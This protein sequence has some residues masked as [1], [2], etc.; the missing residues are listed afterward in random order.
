MAVQDYASTI[1]VVMWIQVAIA[2]AFIGMRMYTRYF[3]IRSVGL[4]D[5]IMLFNLVRPMHCP[6]NLLLLK[7]PALFLRLCRL[8]NDRSHL[9]HRQEVRCRGTLPLLQSHHVG[10]HRSRDMHSRDCRLQKLSRCLP[11]TYCHSQM[12]RLAS[13]VLYRVDDHIVCD[14]NDA[15]ISAV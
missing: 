10:S 6:S 3:L 13:L 2:I 8:H 15:I 12:A 11:S 7:P 14:Y 1:L 9:R 5:I 4:D